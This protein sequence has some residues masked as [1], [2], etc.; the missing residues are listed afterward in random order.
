MFLF[1]NGN[2]TDSAKHDSHCVKF[3]YGATNQTTS[4]KMTAQI[5]V[6]TETEAEKIRAYFA[7]CKLELERTESSL[8]EHMERE[9][10]M[11]NEPTKLKFQV[12][13]KFFA[14]ISAHA[15]IVVIGRFEVV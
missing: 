6:E 7:K 2:N 4:R 5:N 12:D 3:R 13:D 1:E 15:S 14:S 11:F 9:S 10:L 8:L